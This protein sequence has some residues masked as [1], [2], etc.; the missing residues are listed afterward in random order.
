M[1]PITHTLT[2]LA[3]GRAG[4]NRL[5]VH[6]MPVLLLAANAADIDLVTAPGGAVSYLHYHRHVTHAFLALPLLALLPVLLVRLFA[7]KPFDWKWCYVVSL[8]GVASH[9]LLD[10]M[11]VYGIRLLLPFSSHWYRLD[12]ASL[13]DVWMLGVLLAAA[14]A[15]LFARLVGSEIGARSGTGRGWALMALCFLVLYPF[16][17]YLLHERAV[18]VLDARVY[19][20]MQPLQVAALPGP[21]NPFRWRGLVE[22]EAFYAILDVNLLGDFDPAAGRL[23]YKPEPTPLEAAA[24][25][26]AR[27]TEAFR[28]F[29]DFSQ[30]PYWSF[31][32]LD[33]PENGIR[34]EA[35]DL[36]FGDPSRRAFVAHA[37]VDQTGRVLDS[38]FSY[39]KD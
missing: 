9:P 25:A 8:A 21:A 28:V 33:H 4:L 14:L 13:P 18:A 12:I 15:P 24:M 17:R 7:R 35:S 16:G 32:P 37:V 6:A 36:R 5:S 10:W 11:N 1:D 22:T 2:G 31:T 39:R 19:G 29:L 20:G 34:V 27:R 3:L 38:G 23:L 30:C 26:A